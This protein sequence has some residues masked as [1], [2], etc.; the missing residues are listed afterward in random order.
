MKKMPKD[1]TL[2]Q[3]EE[4]MTEKFVSRRKLWFGGYFENACLKYL[5]NEGK[6][7]FKM[8]CFLLS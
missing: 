8:F 5:A 2:T 1:K 4:K 7:F 3:P 6:K